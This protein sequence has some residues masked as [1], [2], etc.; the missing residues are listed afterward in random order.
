MNTINNNYTKKITY[1]GVMMALVCVATFSISFPIA[2]T[3]GY[4]H[5]GD[6]FVFLSGIILGPIYG[7]LVAGIGSALA[8]IILGYTSWAL[9]TFIIKALMAFIIGMVARN[10]KDKK[11]LITLGS[12]FSIIWIGFTLLMNNLLSVNVTSASTDLISEVEGVETITELLKLSSKVQNILWIAAIAMP[13]IIIIILV[14]TKKYVSP[15]ISLGFIVAGLLMVILY[16]LT[17]YTLY[18]NYI[19]PI[20]SIPAN[21]SQFIIGILIAN[22]LLPVA[23]KITSN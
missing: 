10:Y 7:A 11:I 17:Y 3:G 16:Y 23:K 12:I 4:I 13:I 5:L 1:S 18:G 9:P 6:A 8:D 20:F 14:L 21:I 19:A 22:L 2:F 15:T